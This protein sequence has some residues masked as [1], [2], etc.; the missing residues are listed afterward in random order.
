MTGYAKES[1]L[2]VESLPVFNPILALRS[3][4][5]SAVITGHMMLDLRM[6]W[7]SK[8]SVLVTMMVFLGNMEMSRACIGGGGGGGG[9]RGKSLRE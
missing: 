4:F 7:R 2:P 8:S 6:P 1:T 9:G 5:I 3:K